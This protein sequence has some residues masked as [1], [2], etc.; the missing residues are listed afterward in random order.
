MELSRKLQLV[1]G[2][3]VSDRN[4]TKTDL[5]LLLAIV[6]SWVAS[7]LKPGFS[8]SRRVLMARSRIRSTST[9]HKVIKELQARGHIRY[10]P[11]FH[12]TTA[13]EFEL[14]CEPWEECVRVVC[15][16]G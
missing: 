6:D 8:S 16:I 13:S 1:I 5:V 11:S 3:A 2:R 9:Y 10:R 12:P 7:G 15:A 14:V 4:L